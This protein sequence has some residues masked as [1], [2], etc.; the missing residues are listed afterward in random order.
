MIALIKL[1][2]CMHTTNTFEYVLTG[3]YMLN[4]AEGTFGWHR[5]ANGGN[6]FM[7]IKQL[8]LAEKNSCFEL[9]AT[10]SVNFSILI[11]FS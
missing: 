9:T 1:V 10:K 6:F 4:P 8:L 11:A 7:S 3:K 5:Q 2:E